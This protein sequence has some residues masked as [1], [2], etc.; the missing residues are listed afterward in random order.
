MTIALDAGWS[1]TA[2]AEA[3]RSDHELVEFV[4]RLGVQR[5]VTHIGVAG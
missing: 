5:P 4:Q 1:T 3:S 2:E